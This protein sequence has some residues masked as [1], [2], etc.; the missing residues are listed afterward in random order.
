MLMVNIEIPL[1]KKMVIR[2]MVDPIELLPLSN[3]Y[4]NK[5]HPNSIRLITKYH[6]DILPLSLALPSGKLT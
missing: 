6:H 3:R 4:C 1:F 5:T 2:G